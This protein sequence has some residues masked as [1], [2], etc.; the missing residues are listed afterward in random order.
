MAQARHPVHLHPRPELELVPGHRGAD[1]HAGELGDDAELGERRLQHLAALL[2][3][4]AV[5]LVLRA[6]LEHV[7]GRELPG[8]GSVPGAEVDRHLP[9]GLDGCA[10][11][12]RGVDDLVGRLGLELVRRLDGVLVQLVGGL[13]R[14]TRLV[15]LGAPPRRP[16][17]CRTGTARS[18]SRPPSA[19]RPRSRRR[20]AASGRP[21]RAGARAARRRR[22]SRPCRRR[23]RSPRAARPRRRRADRRRRAARP[24]SRPAGSHRRGARSPTTASITSTI[25]RPM[26][27][28]A[29]ARASSS[30]SAPSSS[31]S[32]ASRPCGRYPANSSTAKPKHA[33]GKTIRPRPSMVALPSAR[34]LP[35]DP[36]RSEA[37][38]STVS[39]PRTT[40]ADRERVGAVAPQ[41]ASGGLATPLPGGRAR[42]SAPASVATALRGGLPTARPRGRSH[43]AS[44][45]TP[46]SP[47]SAGYPGHSGEGRARRR[48]V[49]ARGSSPR[50]P[51]T[52]GR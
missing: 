3:E 51:G 13:D 20:H 11:R 31:R 41:L 7:R 34:K 17:G 47:D 10:R 38:P 40:S 6:A 48:R 36:A 1:R 37:S 32:S 43:R 35:T 23:R 27:S 8:A 15:L 39:T 44:T 29:G 12:W 4:A 5:D 19:P 2:D 14:Y 50:R 24:T 28:G 33:T 45:V 18:A 22:G 42:R 21:A 16:R 49:T 9:A 46:A 26:R 30:S 52:P 25:P